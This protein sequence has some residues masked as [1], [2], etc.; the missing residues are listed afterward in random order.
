[1]ARQ[2]RYSR[3][4]RT[5]RIELGG[6]YPTFTECIPIFT[7]HGLPATV[8]HGDSCYEVDSGIDPKLF[9]PGLHS[10]VNKVVN[11]IPGRN[12]NQ[13]ERQGRTQ[14]KSVPAFCSYQFPT[15]KST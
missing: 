13:A 3:L 10:P 15:G 12:H 2:G 1:M 4:E 8:P 7:F 11:E 14:N 5:R 6:G 9:G